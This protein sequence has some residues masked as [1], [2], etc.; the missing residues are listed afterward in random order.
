NTRETVRAT[1]ELDRMLPLRRRHLVAAGAGSLGLVVAVATPQIFGRQVGHADGRL[2]SADRDWLWVT[3]FA[4]LAMLACTAGAWRSALHA[5]GGRLGYGKAAAYYGTGS[6]VNTLTPFRLGD[7]VRIGLFSRTLRNDERLWTTGSAFGAI[8]AARAL[9][10][11]VLVLA[12]AATGAVPVWP[13]VGAGVIALAGIAA[14]VIARN[15]RPAGRVGHLFDAF[16]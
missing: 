3:A 13:A 2:A 7:A 12:A 6:L 1:H 16:R 14:A 15:R 5:C 10:L 9:A 11:A 8:G 4:F